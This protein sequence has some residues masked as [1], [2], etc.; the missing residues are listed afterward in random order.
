MAH[1]VFT[2]HGVVHRFRDVVTRAEADDNRDVAH[3]DLSVNHF[4]GPLLSFTRADL[5]VPRST[6]DAF[7]LRVLTAISL[8]LNVEN[9]YNAPAV[10]RSRRS[11]VVSSG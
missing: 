3:V 11:G 1:H 6:D 9:T 8:R 5:F 4:R 10:M 2:A 7:P